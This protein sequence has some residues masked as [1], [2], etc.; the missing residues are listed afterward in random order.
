MLVLMAAVAIVVAVRRRPE[1]SVSLRRSV[2]KIRTYAQSPDFA[3]PWKFSSGIAAFGTGFFIGNGRILT[4]AHVISD[5]K[6][7][8]IQRSDGRVVPAV[9]EFV[10]HDADLALLTIK[11]PDFLTGI[12]PLAFGDLPKLRSPVYTIGFPLGGE[13]VSITE[14]VVSR[15]DY[16]LYVHS[17]VSRHLMVQV[18]SAINPGNSGGPVVQGGRVV[19]VAFQ[20]N[21]GAQGAGYVI[22]TPVIERFLKDVADGRYDGHPEDG[23]VVQEGALVNPATARFFGVPAG[24]QGVLVVDV[25]GGSP[26]HERVA[27]SDVLMAVDG[28]PIGSDG[29][30]S[31]KG[32]RVDF[33]VYYDLRQIGETV[34][35]S[36]I[37]DGR[38]RDV[39]VTAAAAAG[40]YSPARVFPDRP[41]Y[42]VYGGLVF[43][44]LT[45]N[46]LE[47]YGDDWTERAP[48]DLRFLH[49]YLQFEPTFAGARTPVVMTARLPHA[50]NAYVDVQ[51]GAVLAKVDGVDVESFAHLRTLIAAATGEL[52]T[53]EFWD[54]GA[55]A[56][57]SREEVDAASTE[58]AQ[59]Y[60]IDG[61]ASFA[62]AGSDGDTDEEDP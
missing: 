21:L 3:S 27:K 59:T 22:P 7:I 18:D 14:G 52:I 58:I 60:K 17:G 6:F 56:V 16:R 26:F 4:N 28:H 39:Q 44:P 10:A 48:L 19:G 33:R 51:P 12:A 13:K 8:T 36:V 43:E 45:R 5:A 54:N 38:Q 2:F 49:R 30:V 1:E 50:V 9:T 32:E 20:A 31:Y 25:V 55:L 15:I 47:T 53:F 29:R 41:E 11:G 42:L 62:K 40:T 46:Y 61:S 34:T 23:L 24:R 57:L 37:R 35:L